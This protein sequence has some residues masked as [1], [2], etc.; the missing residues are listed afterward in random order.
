M[1][2]PDF[3][4]DY[5]L[6]LCPQDKILQCSMSGGPDA[7][8]LLVT[9]DGATILSK[10]GIDNPVA[11]VLVGMYD[12]II[13]ECCSIRMYF[14]QIFQKY[15][16]MK[17]VMVQHQLLFWLA[18]FFEYDLEWNDILVDQGVFRKRRIYSRKKFILKQ[19]SRDGVRQRTKHFECWRALRK[20]TGTVKE[21]DLI[22][23]GFFFVDQF[24][25]RT[26]PK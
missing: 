1:T 18:N 23:S 11:K 26:V 15:R 2:W 22:S 5:L 21:K 12:T 19:S 13:P 10:I 24:E 16:T 17:L 4:L 6:L 8:K 7:G 9:N 20:T 25:Y 3:L 14:H